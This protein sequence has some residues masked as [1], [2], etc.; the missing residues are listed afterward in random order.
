MDKIKMLIYFSLLLSALM[1]ILSLGDFLALHDIYKDYVS[2]EILDYLD[3]TLEKE[4][5]A[6]TKTDGEWE[7]VTF[8]YI[9][10]ATLL[11]V[12]VILLSFTI[13]FLNIK[14]IRS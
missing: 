1:F 3:I 14:K 6:W 9:S 5:P 10:R 8:N 13:R 4:L 11:V 12:N 2:Q 7:L